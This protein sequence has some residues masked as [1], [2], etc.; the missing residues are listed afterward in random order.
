MTEIIRVSRLLRFA[1]FL[2]ASI[3]LFC[4]VLLTLS[5][6][7]LAN[8]FALP[9]QLLFYA[10]L[11]FFPFSALLIYAA[12]RKSISKTIVWLIIAANLIWTVDSFLMLISGFVSPTTF[13]Y[14]F[15][16][17]Q[18]LSVLTFA[19]LQF[20]GMRKSEVVVFKDVR[21]TI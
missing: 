2:D 17:I 12:T 5:S 9:N 14:I 15:V 10:G 18:A 16:V 20:I 13:G 1:L 19:D 6:S 3:S 11:S 7:Y 8:L 4:G 21:E